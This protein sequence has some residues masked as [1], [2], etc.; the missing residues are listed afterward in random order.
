MREKL[1]Y[2]GR[3]SIIMT[4]SVFIAYLLYRSIG[5]YYSI[6]DDITMQQLTSGYYTGMPDG[7]LAKFVYYVY[8]AVIARLFNVVPEI[9]WYG[10]ILIGLSFL[11]YSL[12]ICRTFRLTETSTHKI[13][14]R[15]SCVIGIVA[16]FLES[17]VLFQFTVVSGTLAATALFLLVTVRKEDSIFLYILIWGL[18]L[19][20]TMLR[21][22][23]IFMAAPL[24]ATIAVYKMYEWHG[25]GVSLKE[26]FRHRVLNERDKK[27]IFSCVLITIAGIVLYLSCK[28]VE[29]TAYKTDIWEEY[30]EYNH[31]RSLIMDYYGWPS[32]EENEEF[33]LSIDISREEQDCLKMFGILP[34]IDANK[35]KQ[36]AEYSQSIYIEKTFKQKINDMKTLFNKI[37]RY[38]TC[39]VMY[40]FLIGLTICLILIIPKIGKATR[41]FIVTGIIV[42]LLLLMYLLYKG[43]LPDRIVLDFGFQ[44]ILVIYGVLLNHICNNDIPL[45]AKYR[46]IGGCAVVAFLMLLAIFEINGTFNSVCTYQNRMIAY[47]EITDYIKDHSEFVYVSSIGSI[48]TVKQYSIRD[49]KDHVNWFGSYGWSSKSPWYASRYTD[50]GIDPDS[51]ILLDEKVRFITVDLARA[52]SMNTYYVSENLIDHDY[53]VIDTL[54]LSNGTILYVVNWE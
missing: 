51:D 19:V 37:L 28:V 7:H 11:C 34:D 48:D 49:V 5:F 38:A 47:K 44:C 3:F 26:L 35:I 50:L 18:Y 40:V 52:D 25:E 20:S 13:I 1:F 2:I 33:Y 27:R 53:S 43:R 12:I 39:H 23:M 29:E 45:R 4:M 8:G 21:V 14:I 16:L 42:Q 36:I 41:S 9:D 24:F 46:K 6:N 31:Y 30:V 15:T 10:G 22:K 17:T 32:Y 54:T